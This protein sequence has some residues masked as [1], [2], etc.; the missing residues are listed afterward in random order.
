M[1]LAIG[2]TISAAVIAVLAWMVW[3]APLGWEDETGFH[4]GEPEHSDFDE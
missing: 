1:N 4:L 3:T 2:L